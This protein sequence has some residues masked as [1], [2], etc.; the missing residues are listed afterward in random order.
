MKFVIYEDFNLLLVQVE[1][2]RT[3][4]ETAAAL[5]EFV[6]FHLEFVRL[7]FAFERAALIAGLDDG[8]RYGDQNLILCLAAWDG[9]RQI[10]NLRLDLWGRCDLGGSDRT[11]IVLLLLEE[12]RTRRTFG[13]LV[14]AQIDAEERPLRGRGLRGHRCPSLC[15]VLLRLNGSGRLRRKFVGLLGRSRKWDDGRNG[16]SF[17]LDVGVGQLLLLAAA[18]RLVAVLG[19]P[20]AADLHF[21]ADVNLERVGELESMEEGVAHNGGAAVVAAQL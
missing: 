15:R 13:S 19:E 9:D 10:Y 20:V 17:R 8:R 7:V 5:Q 2:A 3:H 12:S 1:A 11:E 14:A 21:A 16:N 6:V 18:K 4:R